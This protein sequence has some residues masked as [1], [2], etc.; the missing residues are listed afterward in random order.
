MSTPEQLI[1]AEALLDAAVNQLGFTEGELFPADDR[2]GSEAKDEWLDKGDWLALAKSVG[3]ER[4]FFVDQYPVVVFAKLDHQGDRAFRDLYNRIWCMA[5][6]QLLFLA[7]PGELAIYDLGKPPIKSGER[8]EDQG[9]LLCQKVQ[10]AAEVLEKLAG[11]RREEIESG[12]VF[13][14]SR[15]AGGADRADRALIRDLKLV[16]QKLLDKKL[17]ARY[18]HALIGRSIFIRYLEDRAVLVPDYFHNI[19]GRR[20][21]WGKLLAQPSQRPFVES[22]LAGLCYPRVLRDK[23]FTYALFDQ[24][25]EDFNGDIFPVEKQEREEVKPEH[26]E[27]LKGMLL[28]DTTEQQPLFFFAYRF[29]VI[30]IELISSIYEEFYNEQ[31][32]KEKNHGSYY[33]PSALV[34]FVLSRT[35]TRDVLERTPRV[36]DPACGSGI[37]LVESFRRI[38]RHQIWKQGGRRLSRPQLRRILRDQ[39]AGV[40]I[41]EEAVRVAAFSLYL[42]FLHYQEP[43]EINEERRLPNLKWATESHQDREH[44]CDILLHGNA[45]DAVGGNLGPDIARRFGAATADVVVGNPPWGYPKK[46]DKPGR[47]ALQRALQWCRERKR[48]IG[49]NELSQ[50]FVHLALE[51][52]EGRGRAGMLVSSGVFFKH[53]Q[54]SED[55]RK[56]WL[57]HAQLRQVVNF[58]HVR[59][60]F[61][62][63]E[64]RKSESV[65]PFAS[66]IFEK[67]VGQQDNRFE[68]WS[69]KRTAYMETAQ[70][71]VINKGD[72]HWLSQQSCLAYEKIWKIYWWGGHR[73]EALIRALERFPALGSLPDHMPGV[74]ITAGAGYHLGTKENAADWLAAYPEL[75]I[76]AFQSYGPINLQSLRDAPPWVERRGVQEVY[77]G[78]RLLVRRGIRQGGQIAARLESRRFCFR[79]SI[80]GYRLSGLERWQEAVLLGIYWSSLARYYFFLTAGSWGLW[81]DEIHLETVEEMPIHFPEDG[82]LRRRIVHAVE[83]LQDLDQHLDF[84]L[85]GEAP[86]DKE[87]D[88]ER[89]LDDAIFDLYGLNRAERGLVRDMCDVGLDFLYRSES[90]PAAKPVPMLTKKGGTQSDVAHSHDGLGAYLKTFLRIWNNDL[91]P[92]S[93]LAWRVIA[94]APQPPLVAVLFSTRSRTGR[95]AQPEPTDDNSWAE[96]LR[97]VDKHSK[98]TAGSRRLYTDS[99]VRLVSE[100][101]ILL[102]KRNELRFW[103]RSAA[104]ED[105]EATQLQAMQIQEAET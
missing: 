32:G 49:H 84:E 94:P 14:D 82:D 53:H 31:H 22:D 51:L 70:V 7:L 4:V 18:A 56:Q 93:E 17:E 96:V 27:L 33:T 45:F 12:R 2:A 103:T 57:S 21:P 95:A 60:V 98:Q 6:P 64:V 71:V 85:G 3:A 35:L 15:F 79:N 59:H 48:I 16:R 34:D 86:G 73:D 13:G 81:H 8:A 36:M 54:R 104:R 37:F 92:E 40:D 11:F 105:A 66:I 63:G 25:A 47:E 46:S 19:A 30:P 39:V 68:Y 69:A 91:E 67:N 28:G 75:P 102:I 97:S 26:L 76:D 72:M 101:Q 58:G 23:D 100:D 74:R 99:F 44:R 77:E 90:S 1:S 83:S 61:F 10:T 52:L 55:F 20:K 9:R 62:R 87:R 29:D 88:L 5:R 50:A 42:A 78:H 24:L 80:H 43:R 89:D 41:N 38:V 65:A